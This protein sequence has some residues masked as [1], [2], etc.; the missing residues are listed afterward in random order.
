MSTKIKKYS[1]LQEENEVKNVW[2]TSVLVLCQKKLKLLLKN[3]I[4]LFALKPQ[5][6][7]H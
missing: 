3:K 1:K 5:K 7:W 6:F 2:H 4:Y